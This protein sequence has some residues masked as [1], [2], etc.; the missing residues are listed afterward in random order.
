MDKADYFKLFCDDPRAQLHMKLMTT[1][2]T[3]HEWKA[4][5]GET[6]SYSFWGADLAPDQRRRAVVVTL[7]GLSGAALDYEPLARHLPKYRV[8]TF[9]L[10]LRGEWNDPLPL[11]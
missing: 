1:T 8:V 7:H 5:D 4:P 2:C 6:F 11:R 10:E 9:S 3:Q